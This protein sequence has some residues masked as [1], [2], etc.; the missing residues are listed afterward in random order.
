MSSIQGSKN[1]SKYLHIYLKAQDKRGTAKETLWHHK[2]N[3]C[4]KTLIYLKE[5]T[6]EFA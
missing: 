5:Q 2:T 4:P 3:I 6:S 1:Y